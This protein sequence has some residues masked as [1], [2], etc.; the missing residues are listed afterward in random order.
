[1]KILDLFCGKGGWSIPFIE[2]G[3][4]VTGV[5]IVDLHY[6]GRLILEDIRNLDGRR[7]R[8]YDLIIGSPPCNDFSCASLINKTK[9]G[10]ASAPDPK[11]GLDLI[12]HFNRIVNEAKPR[13][14]AMENVRRLEKF[15]PIK[16]IWHFKIG[17]YSWRSLWGNLNLPLSPAFEFPRRIP[18]SLRN[19]DT[20][21]FQKYGVKPL[22]GKDFAMIPYP[23]A[24][25][26]VDC[27][28]TQMVLAT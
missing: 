16:P 5:D 12:K 28:K 14:W 13:Y 23:I 24:R 21:I 27:L 25:F 22:R 9:N 26:I 4:D 6:P 19:T 7:F 17:R 18:H 15:Y 20:E 11:R 3:D 8:D 2:D 10:G 1:M